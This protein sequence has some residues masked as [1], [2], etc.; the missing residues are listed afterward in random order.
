MTKPIDMDEEKIMSLLR[1]GLDQADPVPSDVTAF[2][3]AALSWRSIDAELAE[4][5]YDSIDE[6]SAATVRST[7]STRIVGFEAGDWMIDLEHDVATNELRGHI[8]PAS[9]L[10]VEL[11]VIGAVL[12]TETDEL[13]R[14]SFDGVEAGPV[15]LVIRVEGAESVKTEWI[16]L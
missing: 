4:L 6:A 13:G 7:T 5:S 15:A 8:Q 16:V 11:H 9:R 14:F 3:K 2:G 10:E 12:V 1:R